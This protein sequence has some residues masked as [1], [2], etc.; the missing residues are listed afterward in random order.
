MTLII[1][2]FSTCCLKTSLKKLRKAQLK[3]VTV[4]ILLSLKSITI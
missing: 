4:L 3:Q 1:I 2:L